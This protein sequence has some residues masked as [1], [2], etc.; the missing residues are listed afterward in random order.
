V[1]YDEY[2]DGAERIFR[3]HEGRPHWGKLHS[4]GHSEL[5]ELYPM[6]D[7]FKRVRVQLDPKGVFLNPYLAKV[8]GTGT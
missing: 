2:F 1:K 5:R 3:R 6:W 4:L 8:L 7:E